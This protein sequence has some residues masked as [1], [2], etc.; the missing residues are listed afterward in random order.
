MG[1]LFSLRFADLSLQ[2]S[3]G[4]NAGAGLTGPIPPELGALQNL[5]G[6]VLS[7]NLLSGSIPST[8]SQLDK[9]VSLALDSNQ[10][11]GAMPPLTA[12]ADTLRILQLNDNRGLTGDR[13][14]CIRQSP[15]FPLSPHLSLCQ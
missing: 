9:L 4:G 10:L 3:T 6:L 8:F 1:Q 13:K 5:S 2:V 14:F 7:H 15:F 11:T 12:S